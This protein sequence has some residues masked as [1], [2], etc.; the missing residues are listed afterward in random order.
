MQGAASRRQQPQQRR[1][2]VWQHN[3]ALEVGQLDVG[4][5]GAEVEGFIYSPME[6]L[7]TLAH[8]RI[9]RASDKRGSSIQAAHLC[10]LAHNPLSGIP[11]A[12]ASGAHDIQY[13][14]CAKTKVFDS[15]SQPID[16]RSHH[17]PSV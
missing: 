15:S 12:C 10:N 5:P 4:E 2:G 11:C 14:M 3:K 17:A 1:N 16:T 6:K 7:T 8:L 13:I 9:S